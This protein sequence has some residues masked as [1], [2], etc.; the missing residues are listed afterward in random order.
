MSLQTCWKGTS[1]CSW[2][3]GPHWG[4]RRCETMNVFP[5]LSRHWHWTTAATLSNLSWH[6]LSSSDHKT[7]LLSLQELVLRN[8]NAAATKLI[9]ARLSPRIQQT[10]PSSS[11][12]PAA[13]ACLRH[14][15]GTIRDTSCAALQT[16]VPKAQSESVRDTLNWLRAKTESVA[17]ELV[18]S[19]TAPAKCKFWYEF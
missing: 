6:Q 12:H 13:H 5:S 2:P 7:G 17:T 15:N 10:M 18:Q 4:F 9:C 8:R 11:L 19:W 3:S 14:C 1:L 16:A